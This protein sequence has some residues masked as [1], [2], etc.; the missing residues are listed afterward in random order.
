M[1]QVKDLNGALPTGSNKV[2]LIS[3][4]EIFIEPL[5]CHHTSVPQPEV[6]HLDEPI[7]VASHKDV[8]A[9][10]GA[11]VQRGVVTL[12]V[13]VPGKQKLDKGSNGYM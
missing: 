2:V 7:L 13:R 1:P 9:Q 3:F 10:A 11:A 12:Q 5:E 8:G 6:P 4:Q